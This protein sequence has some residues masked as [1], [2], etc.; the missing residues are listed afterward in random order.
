MG[1]VN[2]EYEDVRRFFGDEGGD[3]LNMCLNF[4]LNQALALAL[5]RQDA[6]TL[7]HCLR[8]MPTHGGRCV[9]ELRAQP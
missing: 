1:E 3:E 7:V 6:G 8:A 5:V 2:L 4:N 9:G